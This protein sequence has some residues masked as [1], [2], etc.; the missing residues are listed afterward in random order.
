MVPM[1][2]EELTLVM[3]GMLRDDEMMN[4]DVVPEGVTEYVYHGGRD[5][6]FTKEYGDDYFMINWMGTNK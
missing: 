2:K 6:M 4:R 5:R 1:T 3:P